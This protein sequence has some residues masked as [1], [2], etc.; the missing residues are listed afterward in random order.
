MATKKPEPTLQ[1]IL[2][3]ILE[4]QESLS[5]VHSKLDSLPDDL[6]IKINEEIAAAREDDA[7]DRRD[8]E[9][10]LDHI[11]YALQNRQTER[12]TTKLKNQKKKTKPLGCGAWIGVI[13]LVLLVATV[14][15][16]GY[17]AITLGRNP[18]NNNAQ[19]SQKQP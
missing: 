13:L 1:D 6:A 4:L 11:Q 5:E 12:P 7:I 14:I 10:R 15:Y 9:H 17:E 18:P 19:S 3:Q 16:A 8:L 2:E